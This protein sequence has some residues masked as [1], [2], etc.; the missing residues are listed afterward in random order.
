MKTNLGCAWKAIRD[1]LNS[2]RSGL[3]GDLSIF[4]FYINPIMKF[5]LKIRCK[6][7][8]V[9][10]LECF[11][12]QGSSMEKTNTHTKPKTD[13]RQKIQLVN[14]TFIYMNVSYPLELCL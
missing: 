3:E 12:K 14:E 2:L 11:G 5:S 10:V 9:R 8:R 1:I 6:M 13:H 4:A 7:A